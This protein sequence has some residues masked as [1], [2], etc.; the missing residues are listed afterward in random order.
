MVNRCVELK[1]IIK[2]YGD[3]TVLDHLSLTIGEAELVAL[4][5]PSGCGKSTTLKVLAGLESPDAG[6]VLI[7]GE[8]IAEVPPRQRNMG[9]VFQAYSLFPHMSA[10]ENVAYGLKIRRVAAAERRRRAEELLEL[11]GL[12]EHRDSLPG[13]LSGGQ[14]QRVALARALAIEPEVLLLDEPLS[15]LDAQ[16]RTQLREEIRRIQLSEGI[17]TLLVTHDQEEAILMADVIGVM[18]DGRLEQ[19]GSPHDIY[20]HPTTPFISHFVGSVNR[21]PG[22]VAEGCIRVAGTPLRIV[23]GENP[24]ARRPAA[25]ALVRP[26]DL[27]LLP[28]LRSR[29]QV[30]TTRPRGLVSS[31]IV[32]DTLSRS[33]LRVD[34]LTRDA[35][36]FHPGMAVDVRVLREDAVV[37]D[38]GDADIPAT[39]PSAPTPGAVKP[40]R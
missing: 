34:M 29:Y 11:V 14:Q 38:L 16:V 2:N 33:D 30:V 5:G 3:R 28:A 8:S 9:I 27:E 19:I 12:A 7:D 37:D 13:R 23:N 26:E 21:I 6:E 39:E 1:N 10:V 24:A 15:A 4:L 40:A 36:R 25:V 35:Q 20:H 22:P 31:V 18:K 17:S 32:T